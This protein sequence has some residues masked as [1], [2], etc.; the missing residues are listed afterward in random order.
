VLDVG[1]GMCMG[2]GAQVAQQPNEPKRPKLALMHDA[3]QPN[4]I[5]QTH[6][7]QAGKWT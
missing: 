1:L 6:L 4:E 7:V 3:Q 5:H 2:P